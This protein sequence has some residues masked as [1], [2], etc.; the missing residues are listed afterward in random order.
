M[1]HVL[2]IMIALTSCGV[3]RADVAALGDISVTGDSERFYAYRAR[4]GGL[5]NY[6]SYLDYVGIAAQNTHYSQRDWSRDAQ[7][8]LG[9]WRRQD[10]ATL[11]GIN[12]E[13]GVVQVAGHTRVVGDATWNVRPRP[14][15][16]FEFIAAGDLVETQPA[17]EQGIAYGFFGVSAEQQLVSRL[18]AIG[19]I[20]YQPFT[21]GNERAHL[22]AR[23]IWDA[24]PDYGVTA[25]LRW[26]QYH[27]SEAD[28]GRAYFNPQNYRQWQGALA[29]RRRVAGGWVWSGTLAAGQETLSNAMTPPTTQPTSLA[30]V[31]AE[32]PFI[33]NTR[34]AIHALYTR[35]TG[36]VD[37][38]NYWYAQFGATLIVPF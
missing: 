17:L 19:L 4:A 3:A 28:V 25:Q 14:T 29:M 37:S 11:A 33:G 35:S 21:D 31:R 30:E 1:K 13:G 9:V 8:L 32:G 12:A 2:T 34:L 10:R 26:K 24:I 6:T 16:A 22:R 7:A 27:S 18:T 15:T 5:L 20:A 38:P 36:Y 23:L